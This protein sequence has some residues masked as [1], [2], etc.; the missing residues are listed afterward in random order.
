MNTLFLNLDL[1]TVQ[2]TKTES[3]VQ[4]NVFAYFRFDVYVYCWKRNRVACV[5]NMTKFLQAESAVRYSQ[6]SWLLPF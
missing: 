6:C 3:A 5:S 2:N 1:F 4:Y